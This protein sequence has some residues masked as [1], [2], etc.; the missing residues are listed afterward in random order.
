[1]PGGPR[2]G[3]PPGGAPNE[4]GCED[5]VSS[6]SEGGLAIL[7]CS[8]TG[9][10]FLSTQH[11]FCSSQ[12][13]ELFESSGKCI[14]LGGLMNLPSRRPSIPGELSFL[15]AGPWGFLAGAAAVP[16][17]FSPTLAFLAGSSFGLGGG[18]WKAD[19]GGAADKGG[20]CR[21]L[22]GGAAAGDGGERV[23]V[24]RRYRVEHA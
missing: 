14:W 8:S 1:M 5:D 17:D 4:F 13:M 11:F 15:S 22:V 23:A 16:F 10:A 2:D 6:M 3:G 12:T 7:A 18:G 24:D 20:G 21:A 9:S 19:V